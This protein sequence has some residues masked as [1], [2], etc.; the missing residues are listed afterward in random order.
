M[1]RRVF[2][3]MTFSDTSRLKF[4]FPRPYYSFSQILRFKSNTRYPW[5]K[6][7]TCTI[8][9]CIRI[10]RDAVRRTRAL[11]KFSLQIFALQAQ[12]YRDSRKIVLN[13]KKKIRILFLTRCYVARFFFF[14]L[15]TEQLA[16]Y[17][18]STIKLIKRVKSSFLI[19]D[20]VF[21]SA[22]C[23]PPRRVRSTLGK[24]PIASPLG[25]IFYSTGDRRV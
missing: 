1:H 14:L 11:A 15:F 9:H 21:P 2:E 23:A 10:A 12:H 18:V 16:F 22:A 4:F 5:E 7:N 19:D 8:T 24:N 20:G 13:D 3:S 17:A 6:K 25:Y